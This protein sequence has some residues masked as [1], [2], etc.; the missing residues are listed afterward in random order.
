MGAIGL[1]GAAGCLIVLMGV[2]PPPTSLASYA[3]MRA[4]MAAI[5]AWIYLPS[6][7]LTLIAGLLAIAANHVYQNAGWAWAKLATGVLM[8]EGSMIGVLGPLQDEA[9]R[10]AAALA[11]HV[12]GSTL[13]ASG[14]GGPNALWGLLAV[15]TANVVLGIWRPRLVRLSS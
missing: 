7:G 12:D 1:M 8:F 14:T 9:K 6:L 11:G 15:M 4:A 10:S 5:A 3:A 13:T 2:A